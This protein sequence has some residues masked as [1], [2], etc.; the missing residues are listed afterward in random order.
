M[1][2]YGQQ[3][4]GDAKYLITNFPANTSITPNSPP[5]M[6]IFDL[7][8][9]TPTIGAPIIANGGANRLITGPD[10]CIYAGQGTTVWKITDTSGACNYTMPSPG[11]SLSL[12]PATLSS[13][14]AQGHAVTLNAT[15][16]NAT[17][18]DGTSV[19]LTVTGANAKTLQANTVGGVA[20]FT[21]TA[22]HQGTDTVVASA[23]VPTSVPTATTI[24]VNSN[25]AVVTW[26]PGSDVTFLT[27]NGSPTGALPGASVNLTANLTDL[28][29][30]PIAPLVGQTVGF[31]LGGSNCSIATDSNGNAACQVTPG[32]SGTMT[33]TG[34]FAGTGAVQSVKRFEEFQLDGAGP[35]PNS[36]AHPDRNS[37]L[38]RDSDGDCDRDGDADR[39]RDADA[40]GRQIAH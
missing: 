9:S 20:S 15:I 21:Y 10:G 5:T 2:A 23:A 24:S 33:L 22:A 3:A 29:V 40:G 11:P 12:T 34:T 36:H 30:N 1:L 31:S 38:D 8:S 37:D 7:T 4:N 25:Q 35:A 28:S 19:L 13:V 14:A 39:D 27:L 18:P 6:S 26:G 17:A 16:H 32:G